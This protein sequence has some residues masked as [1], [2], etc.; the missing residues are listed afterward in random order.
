MV[1]VRP[2]ITERT[3]ITSTTT[4]VTL[5]PPPVE[6]GAAPINMRRMPRNLETTVISPFPIES[7][8]AV[9]VVMDWKRALTILFGTLS[10]PMVLGLFHSKTRKRTNPNRIRAAVAARTILLWRFKC[11]RR[12]KF[13][14]S[15]QTIKPR[16]PATISPPSTRS[17]Q[18]L[19]CIDMRLEYSPF[20]PSRSKPA[21]Q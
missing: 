4:V 7:K 14:R 3:V 12:R 1:S 5:T 15:C 13:H 18:G 9:R 17:T 20:I 6:P 10:S 8:P 2:R 11:R 21:L 16:P 19:F